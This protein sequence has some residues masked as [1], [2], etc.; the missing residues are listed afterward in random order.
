MTSRIL[1]DAV[2]EP[3][4][5]AL[6]LRRDADLDDRLDA[7]AVRA[8]VID[9]GLVGEDDTVVFQL[10]DAGADVLGRG[11]Q[12]GRQRLRR[13]QGVFFQEFEQRV[14]RERLTISG[15]NVEAGGAPN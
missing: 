5:A 14:H 11:G 7:D 4:K 6:A 8:L 15:R 10:R 9:D 12:L 1:R 13:G 3:V 2:G